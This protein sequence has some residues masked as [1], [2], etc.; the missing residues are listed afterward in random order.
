MTLR[1]MLHRNRAA[2]PVGVRS[3]HRLTAAA[4]NSKAAATR[5]AGIVANGVR[6]FASPPRDCAV[7][8]PA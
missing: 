2:R 3:A 7:R 6:R 1:N 5:T 8:R 4:A